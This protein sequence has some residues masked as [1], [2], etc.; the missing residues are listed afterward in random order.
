MQCVV[1][2]TNTKAFV[3]AMHML[4]KVGDEAVIETLKDSV[5]FRALSPSQSS[6]AYVVFQR[7]FFA[8]F[9]IT[10]TRL[11]K[12]SVNLKLC[13][14]ALKSLSNTEH[15][16]MA[17]DFEASLLVFDFKNPAGMRR[18]YEYAFEEQTN[19]LQAD[20][21]KET[22]LNQIVGRPRFLR[23]CVDL[24]HGSLEEITLEA[25]QHALCMKSY[26]DDRDEAVK[27][28][29]HTE[30]VIVAQEFER[31][32]VQQR[33]ENVKVT[34][35]LREFKAMLAFCEALEHNIHVFFDAPGHPICLSNSFSSAGIC[36]ATIIVATLGA[37]RGDE[38]DEEEDF[39]GNTAPTA[40]TQHT[41]A[42]MRSVPVP[43]PVPVPVPVPVLNAPNHAA[44]QSYSQAAPGHSMPAP[45]SQHGTGATGAGAGA[46]A[47]A[48]LAGTAGTMVGA[49]YS[50]MQQQEA[51]SGFSF[52]LH[53]PADESLNTTRSRIADN[54]AMNQRAAT[55]S[56]HNDR[57][58]KRHHATM[59]SRSAAAASY[60]NTAGHGMRSA[61]SA[62]PMMGRY[63]SGRH[64]MRIDHADNEDDGLDDVK[65]A[66]ADASGALYNNSTHRMSHT[67]RSRNAPIRDSPG[68][69]DEEFV[70]ATPQPATRKRSRIQ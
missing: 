23:E 64:S 48:A 49:S 70:D 57:G 11:R 62:N 66:S 19:V 61:R 52:D 54:D 65:I 17:L 2:A 35:C 47:G 67:R 13:A 16:S 69:E 9:D 15:F 26:I 6:Y 31:F 18:R 42:T 39:A 30:Y 21:A 1:P 12:C 32:Q 3:K 63:T 25:G 44:P 46:G 36:T 8:A 53:A 7:E 40:T 27:Q 10:E 20:F 56:I 34:F 50:S 4:Q 38:D 45:R 37:D 43:A 14:N 24:F 22:S 41:D 58:Q 68:T 28:L 33:R 60:R 55:A 51:S 29:L 5:V 59:G